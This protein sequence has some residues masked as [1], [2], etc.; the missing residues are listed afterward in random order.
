M[1]ECMRA[2]WTIRA[3]GVDMGFLDLI[4]KLNYIIVF[5][6]FILEETHILESG[7]MEYFMAREFIALRMARDM[8]EFL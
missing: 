5:N 4:C 6:Q 7:R 2:I 1:K 8:K 3:I